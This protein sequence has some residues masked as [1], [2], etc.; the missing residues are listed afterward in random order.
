MY[1]RMAYCWTFDSQ[2]IR[3]VLDDVG[4]GFSGTTMM[5]D[6]SGSCWA[7]RRPSSEFE[8]SLDSPPSDA[9]PK[10]NLQL[11]R[12][13]NCAVDITII[14]C[15]CGYIWGWMDVTPNGELLICW[16]IGLYPAPVVADMGC[17]VQLL[18]CLEP[19]LGEFH[20]TPL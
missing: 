19:F 4:R 7:G 12:P 2:Y 6:P 9:K 13:R 18:P 5:T 10:T 15:I 20:C 11:N 1:T 8:P 17:G 16:F 3:I 14:G